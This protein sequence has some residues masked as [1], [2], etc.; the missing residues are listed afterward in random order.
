MA[1]TTD[2]TPAARWDLPLELL[3]RGESN[4]LRLRLYVNGSPA[5]PSVATVSVYDSSNTALVNE[6]SAT[7]AG[8]IA[9]YTVLGAVTTDQPLGTGY[10]VVWTAD[11]RT[12]DIPAALC[13]RLVYPTVT[14]VDVRRRWPYL[15]SGNL[16][17]LTSTTTWQ[18]LIDDAWLTIQHRLIEAGRR[19]WLVLSPSSLREP[20]LLLAG[21]RI[22]DALASRGNP[23][24]QDRAMQLHQMYESAYARVSMDYDEDD[25]GQVDDSDRRMAAEASVWLGGSPSYDRWTYGR[26]RR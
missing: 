11:G 25:D 22:H 18:G 4:V 24:M 8:G 10:R 23:V 7:I 3:E 16:G 15:D 13:R 5:P 1:T 9:S 6:Q 21:A 26:R 12:Y 2:S 19:P 14:D 20:H 17:A